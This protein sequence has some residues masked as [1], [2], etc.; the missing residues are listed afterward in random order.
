MSA[1]PVPPFPPTVVGPAGRRWPRPLTPRQK[2]RGEL[3]AKVAGMFAAS[4]RTYGSPRIDADLLEADWSVSVS[5][6]AVSQR[7]QGLQGGKRKGSQG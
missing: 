6:L 3:D 5:T 4:R 7:R 1:L 2:R